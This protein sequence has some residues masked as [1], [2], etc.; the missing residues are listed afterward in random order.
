MSKSRAECASAW[1]NVFA[2]LGYIAGLIYLILSGNFHAYSLA[3]VIGELIGNFVC[4]GIGFVV[5]YVLG[6]ILKI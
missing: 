1:G 2:W 6:F 4:A 5:G 3:F